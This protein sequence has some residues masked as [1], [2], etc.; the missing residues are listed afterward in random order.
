MIF[1]SFQFIWLFPLI[2]VIYWAVRSGNRGYFFAKYALLAIS[3]GVYL[4]WSLTFGAILL[5]VTAITYISARILSVTDT[6]SRRK[7]VIWIGVLATLAPLILFKYFNFI[8]Q[9][10]ASVLAWIGIDTPPQ[11]LSW[12]VPLGL[13][14]YTF[15]ALGYLWDVYRHKIKAETNWWDYMLFVSFFPQLLCGPISTAAELLP[16]I[17]T[18]RPFE[19][20][21]G[22]KGLRYILWG[23]FL[24]VVV[25]DRLAVYV[26]TV[27][28]SY[29][30]FDGSSCALASLFYTL[31]IYGDFAGYSY[32]A[33][34]VAELLGISLIMNFR[35]PYFA[36][37]VS[38]FWKR[39]NITL[40]RWLTTY[41]YIPLGGS[42]RGK[43]RT[44]RN[45]LVTF[46]VSGIW[47]GANWTFILWGMIHGVF[48]CIEKFFGLNAR[49]SHGITRAIRTLVTLLI[50][51]MAWIYFRAP[52][53]DTANRFI[54]RIFTRWDGHLFIDSRT[55]SHAF[56]AIAIAFIV[57]TWM[58]YGRRSFDKIFNSSAA[59]RWSAY[60]ILMIM[61]LTCGV[62]DSGQF[63]YVQF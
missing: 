16:Q 3:Y 30:N 61:I 15:Q 23:M 36:T 50:V 40:T 14:F 39:W 56:A 42:R 27:Y 21:A 32:M 9:A 11:S 17:K 62:L 10:G 26:D 31:Q 28:S 34:G 45:I 47:H 57:E 4:Q 49:V 33:V 5:T 52:D 20:S 38:E 60:C 19:Y 59:I 1:N 18:P 29:T 63:I 46:L 54:A 51:N 53:I 8:T 25:A 44:Y 48:Q 22:V 41:V 13:S 35:R 7:A 2:F 24:K 6:P 58:E 12:V 43:V 37:S 55:M